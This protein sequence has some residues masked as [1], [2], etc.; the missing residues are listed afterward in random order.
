MTATMLN[1]PAEAGARPA[2][3]DTNAPAAQATADCVAIMQSRTKDAVLQW[4]PPRTLALDAP[5][6]GLPGLKGVEHTIIFDPKPCQ[7]NANE[8]GSGK[9]ESPW[10]GTYNHLPDLAR[11]GNYLIAYW[12]NHSMDETGGGMRRLARVGVLN[13]DRTA[14]DW[15][16]PERVTEIVPPGAPVLK[17][18]WRYD[19]EFVRDVLVN[20]SLREINNRLYVSGNLWAIVGFAAA[21]LPAPTNAFRD[22]NTRE[23]QKEF[24][25]CGVN[26]GYEF[27]QRLKLD[28]N[29]RLLPDGPMFLAGT[30][31]VARVEVTPGRFKQVVPILEP[32]ASARP[33]AEAPAEMRADLAGGKPVD[34]LT[35]RVP[36]WAPDRPVAADGKPFT[37]THSAEFKRPD[38]KWVGLAEG[39]SHGRCYVASLKDS[40]NEPYPPPRVSNL[41]GQVMPTAGELPDGRPWVISN[42]KSRRF[43]FLT[44]S[45]DGITFDK[46]WLLLSADIPPEPE[47]IGKK[48]GPQYFKSLVIG[49]NIW[50]IYSLGK[51]K[52]GVTRIPIPELVQAAADNRR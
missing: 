3:A 36:R 26:L 28:A 50:V 39:E 6:L 5:D 31:K 38:G 20:A 25:K 23:E 34:F 24:G 19:P 30:T 8:G 47:S 11:H 46:S 44:L 42:F 32:Y 40:P 10:H 48:G 43:M 27:V 2:G 22:A 37:A 15:G 35:T 1:R 41:L 33:L 16:G 17:R 52:V 18:R 12:H 51:I 7:A 29:S 9:Y 14:I 13:A 45:D 21:P 4:Q 49:D